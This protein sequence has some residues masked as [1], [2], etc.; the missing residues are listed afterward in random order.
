M[1]NVD[2]AGLSV[3]MTEAVLTPKANRERM[4]Q[5]MFETF[6]V[7]KF[8][9]LSQDVLALY[10]SG[11]TTGTSLVCGRDRT[12]CTPIYE[13]Y[14]ECSAASVAP[15]GG[16][17]L[18]AYLRDLCGE[19]DLDLRCAE[20]LKRK[21][22][23]ID[24]D[25]EGSEAYTLPDGQSVDIER[26]TL[27]KCGE[28]MFCPSLMG[29]EKAP[30]IGRLCFDSIMRTSVSIRKDLYGNVVLSGGASQ[31]DGLAQRLEKEVSALA[32]DSMRIK[33]IA[34][35]EREFA[36]WI[37]GSI[38]ASLSTFKEMWI[39]KDEYPDSGPSIVHRKCM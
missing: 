7:D 19:I 23:A 17:S 39:S 29:L 8:Y 32:P 33:V 4:T 14:A 11:R 20:E 22:G 36:S 21:L 10:A 26:D 12:W 2:P 5:I 13:G 18:S 38:L 3:L 1:L 27:W 31:M 9:V 25:R 30:G 28:A 16:H 6:N 34:T 35:D 24:M 37:G 15:F